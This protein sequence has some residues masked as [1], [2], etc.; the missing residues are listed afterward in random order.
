VGTGTGAS[1]DD[2]RPTGPAAVPLLPLGATVVL[3]GL[4][5][6]VTN[7]FLAVFLDQALHT[8]PVQTSVFLV[9]SAVASILAAGLLGRLSDR[10]GSRRPLLVW[11][12]VCGAAGYVCFAVVR[13]YL[14][15]L[16]VST[17]LVAVGGTLFAQVFAQARATFDRQAPDRAQL[18]VSTLRTLFSVTWVIGPPA[19]GLLLARAGFRG[20]YVAGAVGLVA[21]GLVVARRL[22]EPDGGAPPP[23]GEGA[24]PD[25]ERTAPVGDAAPEPRAVPGLLLRVS[26][27][28]FTCLQCANSLSVIALPLLFSHELGAGVGQAGA[29]LGLCAAL[30]IPWILG[31]GM[32]A[33]RIPLQRLIMFGPPAG[34][35]YYV[36]V[37][38]CDQPWQVAAG[39]VVNAAYI[40]VVQGLGISWFQGLI[41]GSPGRTTAAFVTSNRLAALF[42]GPVIGACQHFG[43]RMAYGACLAL[44]VVGWGV[45][46]LLGPISRASRASRAPR[47]RLSGPAAAGASRRP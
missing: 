42:S 33:R 38:L 17:T 20:L 30:E 3:V 8:G 37:L 47:T 40:A 5:M 22:P 44:V 27:A 36:L 6:A 15:L 35:A 13:D 46:A 34:A 21:A 23:D 31:T 4:A 12:A 43:Y 11:G 32:L 7:P 9:T 39:Q 10:V 41:P 16:L 2:R 1:S 45:L 28:A 19:A 25:G 26:V 14:T 18:L 29:V 24:A